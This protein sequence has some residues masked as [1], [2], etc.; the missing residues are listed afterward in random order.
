[1]T[2]DLSPAQAD[3]LL[4]DSLGSATPPVLPTDWKLENLLQRWRDVVEALPMREWVAA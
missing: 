4:L 3:D 1:M 2:Q